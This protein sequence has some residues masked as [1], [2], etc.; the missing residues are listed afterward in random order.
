MS[1]SPSRQPPVGQQVP[2]TH[3]AARLE[4]ALRIARGSLP[5]TTGT[6]SLVLDQSDER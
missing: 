2:P 6:G 3:A 5:L 4:G 1:L